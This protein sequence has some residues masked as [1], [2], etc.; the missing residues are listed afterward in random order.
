VMAMTTM[1]LCP[2]I[3]RCSMPRASPW[4][5]SHSS[6]C[7]CRRGCRYGDLGLGNS[8]GGQE[9]EQRVVLARLPVMLRIGW[10]VA[11]LGNKV[12]RVVSGMGCLSC[13]PVASASCGCT[14]AVR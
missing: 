13:S 12:H 8:V 5:R 6:C 14:A 1:V 7:S 2:S 4:M 3:G 11:W 9:R 10:L